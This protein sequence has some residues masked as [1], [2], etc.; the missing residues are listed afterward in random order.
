MLLV[1]VNIPLYLHRKIYSKKVGD[2]KDVILDVTRSRGFNITRVFVKETPKGWWVA[3]RILREGSGKLYMLREIN[4]MDIPSKLLK[5]SMNVD[6]KP[7]Y[8]KIMNEELKKWG[9]RHA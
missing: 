5:L 6:W 1:E 8:E 2:L 3:L 4:Y 7:E 9:L